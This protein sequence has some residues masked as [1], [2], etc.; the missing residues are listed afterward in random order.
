[1]ATILQR[2]QADGT[3]RYTVQI[4][5][6]VDGAAHRE[7]RTFATKHAAATWARKREDELKGGGAQPVGVA[8][9]TI[10]RLIADYLCEQ[11]ARL[12]RSKQQHLNLLSNL[13]IADMDAIGLTPA[14]LVAH[15]RQRRERGTGPATVLNDLI[16]LRVIWRHAALHRVPVNMEVIAEA[17]TYCK[18][19]K[20]VAKAKQRVRRPTSDELRRIGAYFL[21]KSVRRC[22]APPMYLILWAA[23]YSCRRL[24]EL[25][26]MRL[27][28]WDRER[29]VWLVRDVKH[30]DGSSG[31][32]LEMTVTDRL[33]PVA[34]ALVQAF[35]RSEGDDRLV[36]MQ[37][38]TVG[39]QWQ[40]AMKL[41][42][43][44]DLHWH[45]LR[46]EGASRLAEDGLTIPQI[47]RVTLHESW[48][49][50]ER[51]VHVPVRVGA[52]VEWDVGSS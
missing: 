15:V 4:R 24:D 13:P 28:D 50:L 48:S 5:L 40:R 30:P 27:S 37:S 46:H 7:S 21:D 49:S 45:D 2:K 47:Q 52:R 18:A 51:Y 20:L 34:E 36:P 25:C 29:G 42:G 12:G 41:L 14:Q 8:R 10:G 3:V 1:M 16:W 6:K 9:V 44:A 26:R 39:T 33:A 31:H 11:G 32:H 43:I 35:T 22:N 23:I 19:E 38:K 17:T